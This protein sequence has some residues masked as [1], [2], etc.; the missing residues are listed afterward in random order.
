MVPCRWIGNFQESF[1]ADSSFCNCAIAWAGRRRPPYSRTSTGAR[2][3][4]F[5]NFLPNLGDRG[6][7]TIPG[8]G[9]HAIAH[10]VELFRDPEVLIVNQGGIPIALGDI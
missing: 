6:P 7:V 3:A 10:H 2:S 4:I 9:N 1:F 8:Y 5:S